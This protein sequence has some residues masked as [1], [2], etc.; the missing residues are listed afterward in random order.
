MKLNFIRTLKRNRKGISTV[1]ATIIIVAIS[2]VMAISVAYWALGIG[3][4]FTQFEKLQITGSYVTGAGTIN[5]DLKNTGSAT[6]TV[7][8]VFLN[9]QP[10]ASY[11]PEPTIA[12]AIGTITAGDTESYAITVTTGTAPWTTGSTV[13]VEFK[14]SAGNSYPTTI[15]LP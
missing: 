13:L 12:P 10:L 2:I 7:T 6:A 15:R 5:V 9:G 4:S 1:I 8:G 3:N 14:T 11:D